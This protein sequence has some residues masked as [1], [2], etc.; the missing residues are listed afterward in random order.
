MR[1]K[2]ILA[3]ASILL[4]IPADA[5]ADGL[6]APAR[7]IIL[8]G[9]DWCAPCVAELRELPALAKAAAP[10]R[11]V[12]AWTDRS[13][14]LP[15]EAAQLGVTQVS[16]AKA[17]ELMARYGHGNSGLPLV[18]MLSNDGTA[19]GTLRERLSKDGIALLLASCSTDRQAF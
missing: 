9:A 8:I 6:T 7:T 3:I 2:S 14:R 19:C 1:F 12:L 11:L 13:A 4:A 17:R 16:L 18:V 10:N 15:P 5:S